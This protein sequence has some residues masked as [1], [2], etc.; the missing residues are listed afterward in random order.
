MEYMVGE[1]D[2]HVYGVIWMYH[3]HIG[4]MK[5]HGSSFTLLWGEDA[6]QWIYMK[7]DGDTQSIVVG[8]PNALG[9]DIGGPIQFIGNSWSH[10]G[11]R[12]PLGINS[13]GPTE[14]IGK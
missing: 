5:L 8:L 11:S 10:I 4:L 12:N 1:G 6:L 14:Y 13:T 7:I 9:L 2:F 3:L